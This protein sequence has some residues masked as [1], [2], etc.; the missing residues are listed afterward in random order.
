[1]LK[2]IIQG[3]ERPVGA[4]FPPAIRILR[5][6]DSARSAVELVGIDDNVSLPASLRRP[7]LQYQCTVFTPHYHIDGVE[8]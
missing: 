6:L 3:A 8:E 1:M 4:L 7:L 2:S 5:P